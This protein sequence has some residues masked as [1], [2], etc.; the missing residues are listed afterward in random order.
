[1]LE[2]LHWNI[3]GP[4]HAIFH[5]KLIS[6]GIGYILEEHFHIYSNTDLIM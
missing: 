4:E 6:P 5:A 3:N 2:I 1:M